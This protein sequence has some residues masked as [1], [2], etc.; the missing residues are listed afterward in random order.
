LSLV[1]N[2]VAKGATKIVQGKPDVRCGVWA[3][4]AVTG[5]TV[6]KN[7]LAA[8]NVLGTAVPTTADKDFL[9][10]PLY[11]TISHDDGILVLKGA[12][13]PPGFGGTQGVT[14]GKLIY[15]IFDTADAVV[16]G[17]NFTESMGLLLHEFTYTKQYQALGYDTNAFGTKYMFQFCKVRTVHLP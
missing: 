14:M 13:L 17:S 5:Y 7:L 10:F 1:S 11:G 2:I 3:S 12:T 6:V 4:A 15:S 8:L 9:I 16:S